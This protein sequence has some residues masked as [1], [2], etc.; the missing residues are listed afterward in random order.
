M[1]W[2]LGGLALFAAY[3]W[4]HAASAT[5]AAAAAPSGGGPVSELREMQAIAADPLPPPIYQQYFPL[6]PSGP[7]ISEAVPQSAVFQDVSSGI[8]TLGA[9]GRF[10]QRRIA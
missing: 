7:V 1:N 6:I 10:G 8:G 4:M 3:E 9:I 2:L 5:Q